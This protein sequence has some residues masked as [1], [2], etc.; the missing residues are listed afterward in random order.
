MESTYFII[1]FMLIVIFIS[2][3]ESNILATIALRRKKKGRNRQN[4]NELVL[5]YIGKK[6]I[7]STMSNSLGGSVTGIIKSVNDSWLEVE[8]QNGQTEI[9]NSEYIIRIKE[10]PVNKKGKEKKIVLE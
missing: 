9:I 7:I 1:F 10:Y 3:R 5:K 4:M 8:A 2:A 6:C